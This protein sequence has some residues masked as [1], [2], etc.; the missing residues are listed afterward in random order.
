MYM[1]SSSL[2]FGITVIQGFVRS[3]LAQAASLITTPSP[4]MRASHTAREC[5]SNVLS[6]TRLA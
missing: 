5:A 1:R 4:D 2:L 6:R 3:K